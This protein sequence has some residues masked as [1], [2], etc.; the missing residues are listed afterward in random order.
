MRD[1][2]A[3]VPRRKP[4]PSA[5]WSKLLR[6]C[7]TSLR[8]G[9]LR[10]RTSSRCGGCRR[11]LAPLADP[12]VADRRQKL[13]KPGAADAGAR[14]AEIVINDTDVGPAKLSGSLDQSILPST[15][16]DVVVHLVDRRLADVD[17][18][19]PGEMITLDPAHGAPPSGSK[20]RP[21][22]KEPPS[23]ALAGAFPV[24]RGAAST[25]WPI[26]D[27]SAVES[28]PYDRWLKNKARR[29]IPPT[30]RQSRQ[31]HA[32]DGVLEVRRKNANR[33]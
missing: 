29:M 19:L 12:A 7:G 32:V 15:A 1:E 5:F 9:A 6:S 20:S 17:N 28:P 3:V 10:E 26:D 11:I 23:E 2:I 16:L 30:H 22:A 25:E 14:T 13:L 31:L 18:R 27:L 33:I 21:S 8:E 4:S 24:E